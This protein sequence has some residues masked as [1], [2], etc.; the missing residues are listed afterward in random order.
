M[1]CSVPLFSPFPPF[2]PESANTLAACPGSPVAYLPYPAFDSFKKLPNAL[3][4]NAL[5][6]LLH[7]LSS[8]LSAN[9]AITTA[10]SVTLTNFPKNFRIL[11]PPFGLVCSCNFSFIL[12]ISY[13]LI[14]TIPNYFEQKPVK[15]DSLGVFLYKRKRTADHR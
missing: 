4:S 9:I 1:S 3:S 5:S 11:L 7:H 8:L 13:Y 10:A 14:L 15:F 2:L 12:L 6:T